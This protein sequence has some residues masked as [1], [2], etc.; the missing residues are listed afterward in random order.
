MAD[1]H[2][3]VAPPVLSRIVSLGDG[4]QAVSG[5]IDASAAECQ[6]L[7]RQIGIQS[8]DSLTLDYRLH[9]IACERFRL[10]GRI[11][12]RL[13]QLCVVTLEPVDER[14]DE[15]VSLECWPEDQ[16]ASDDADTEPDPVF[17]EL[18]DDPPVP[19]IGGK[20]DLGALAAEILAS[21]INPYPRKDDVEFLWEDPQDAANPVS[22]PFG[23]LAKWKPQR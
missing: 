7:A 3:P 5:R 8:L 9:P 16:I 18:P 17:G 20:V 14:I 21:A 22:G 6:A 10:T 1:S 11:T 13:A 23:D 12:A 19:I 2:E 15:E 4:G